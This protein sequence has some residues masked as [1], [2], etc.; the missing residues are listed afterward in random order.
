MKRRAVTA[1]SWRLHLIVLGLA[2]CGLA[3]VA[4][5]VALQLEAT[6]DGAIFLKEQGDARVLRVERLPSGRGV[7]LDRNGELMAFST[8]MKSLWADPARVDRSGEAIAALAHDLDMSAGHLLEK[9]DAGN[10]FVYLKRRLAPVE[11]DQVLAADHAGVAAQIE[12]QRFYPAGEVASHLVGFTD[13]DDRGQEGIELAYESLLAGEWGAKQVMKDR[14]G[15]IIK[16]IRL[17]SA[18]NAGRDLH[19]S[20]DLRLQY[21]AYRELKTAVSE[22]RA[23]SGSM[24]LLDAKTGEVLALVNQPSY[25]ANDRR[26]LVPVDMRNRALIDL[27][28]P[29]SVVKPFTIAAAL[30]SGRYSPQ[31]RIDTSPGYF[32]V[33]RKIFA[34]PRDY[35]EMDLTRVLSKSSQVAMTRIALDLDADRIQ[36]LFAR[37]GLGEYCAT[38]FPGEQPG[39]L[40]SY[41]RWNPID[42]ATL[43]FGHGLSVNALQLAR[44]YT[45]FAN[46]GV[47]QSVTLLKRETAE[48][49]IEAER[50]MSEEIA[51]Q[52]REMMVAVTMPG[53]TGEAARIRGYSV[54]GKTGTAHK[55]GVGG[56]E[57]GKYRSTFVGM[58]PASAPQLIAVVTID[59][60]GGEKYFGGE[61]AA[62]V[63]ANVMR[64]A[65]R[66]LN[67][68]PDKPE[69]LMQ[70]VADRPSERGNDGS[71]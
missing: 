36:S 10:R 49:V 21:A 63:F 19:L 69:E 39:F 58:L 22:Y 71:A 1:G 20:I 66:V 34:D 42:H 48:D 52:V 27:F 53:G 50:V 54:A 40:P 55:V 61:I 3:L 65:V 14:R 31:T 33:G 43:A 7:I 70:A 26:Q 60:P 28:E 47:K 17:L 46:S 67:I 8:P 57:S 2:I 23:R 4:R 29:G 41:R 51:R 13:I 44:A 32:K 37:V 56:Y 59:E 25:N 6:A 38:G 35:G 11:A 30:E 16:D 64:T 9:L 68:A 15:N 18:A 45:V 24:V 62:P 5:L 12:Y